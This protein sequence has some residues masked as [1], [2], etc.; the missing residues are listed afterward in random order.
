METLLT[1]AGLALLIV[2]MPGPDFML[3]TRSVLTGGRRAGVLAAL[4]IAAGSAAWALAAAAGLATL[5]SASPD[6]LGAIRWLGAGYLA[7]IGIR[8]ITAPAPVMDRGSTRLPLRRWSWTEHFRTGMISNLLHPGQVIFYTSM[9]PQFID[10]AGDTTVQVLVLGAVF[11]TIVLTWFATYAVLASTL[12]PRIWDRIT[13][14]LSRI[15]GVVLIG[16][17]VRSAARL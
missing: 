7:W 17:A 9:L 16:F 8:A 11:A 14:A 5:L 3:V 12:R 2:V 13:P 15:T 10:P 1:F 6:L 4:G